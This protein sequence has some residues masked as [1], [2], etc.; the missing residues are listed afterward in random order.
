MDR[1]FKSGKSGLAGVAL[2]AAILMVS[3]SPGPAAGGAEGISAGNVAQEI[4]AATTAED[5]QALADYFREQASAAAEKVKEH[6][7]MLA[8]YEKGGGKPFAN[9]KPHCQSLISSYKAEQKEYEAL[10]DLHAQHATALKK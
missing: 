4:A 8:S 9:M 7:A 1:Q 10:A 3:F 2:A 6:E 5:H